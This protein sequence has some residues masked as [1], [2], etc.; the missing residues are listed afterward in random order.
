MDDQDAQARIDAALVDQAVREGDARIFGI[1]VRRHQGLVRAQ[2]RRL[3]GNDVATADDLAQDTFVLAWRKLHQ[4]RGDSRFATWLYRIAHSC[5]LQ[6][7][8][9]RGGGT[10]PAA[11]PEVDESETS[12]SDIGTHAQKRLRSP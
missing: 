9:S 3:L 5:F 1:L 7:L 11:E 10:Q 12:G 8:R 4:F 6:H 2:L